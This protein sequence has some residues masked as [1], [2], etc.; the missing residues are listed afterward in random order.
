MESFE[1]LRTHLGMGGIMIS[2]KSSKTHPF[3]VKNSTI[4]LLLC[5]TA[6]L[7]AIAS[8]QADSYDEYIDI[9]FQSVSIGACAIPYVIIVW[10]TPILFEFINCLADTVNTSELKILKTVHIFFLQSN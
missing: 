7:I 8:N 1:L 9:L 3:N 4:F 2:Q 5:V 6:I 10:K